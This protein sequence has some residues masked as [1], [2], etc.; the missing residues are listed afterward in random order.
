MAS[1]DLE[2]KVAI[3]TGGSRGL[4]QAIAVALASDGADV[5]VVGRDTAALAETVAQVEATGRTAMSLAE[6]IA[7]VSK[8]AGVFDAVERELGDCG[9]L[10]NSAGLQGDMPAL[11]VTEELYDAVVDIN[12]KSLYFCCQ[13]AGRRM[14]ER[15]QGG[16]IIN[17]GSTFS[18]VGMENFSVYCA[19]KG[20]V[21]LLTKALAIEWAKHGVNVNAIGPTATLTD[22]VAPLFDDPE[23]KAAFMPKVPSGRL[24]EPSDIGKAAAFLAGPGSNM[25]HGHLLMVDCGYTIN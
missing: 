9:I 7:D 10:V 3:V 2:G 21:R 16:K 20:A 24:P 23:F 15:G 1:G 22:M 17:L 12:L 4:G 18:V 14:I 5:A 25:I 6:D 8:I 11:E 13:E 19:T